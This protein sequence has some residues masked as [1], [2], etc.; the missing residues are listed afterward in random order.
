[1][2]GTDGSITFSTALDNKQLEKELAK[3]TK[4]VGKIESQ[5][6]KNGEKRLPIAKQVESLGF[7]LDTAKAKLAA[8]QEEGRRVSAALVGSNANDPASISAYTDAAARQPAL[9]KELAAAQKSVDKLQ[10]KFDKADDQLQSVD[11]TAKKLASDLETAKDKAGK[12]T[13]ELARPETAGERMGAAIDHAGSKMDAFA[14]RVKGLAR[15]V[16]VFTVITAAFRSIKNWMG[17]VVSANDEAAASLAK[18]KGA[19]LTMAQPLMDVVVPAFIVLLNVLTRIV[20]AVAGLTSLLFG[21]T[22]QQSKEAAKGLDKEAKAIQA[23]GKAADAASKSLAGFDEIN[24]LGSNTSGNAGAAAAA[25]D[26]SFDTDAMGADFE[27]LLGWIKLIGTALLYWKLPEGLHGGLKTFFGLLLAVNGAIELVKSTWDAWQDGASMDNFLRML[28]S[29]AQLAAGLG[30]AFGKVGAGIGLLVTGLTMLVTGFH[31]AMEV[32]W[33]FENLLMVISG[34]LISGLGI[35]VLTGSWIPLLIAA[36]VGLLVELAVA[37]GHGGELIDGVQQISQGFVDFITGIFTGDIGRALDGLSKMFEGLK[38]VFFALLEGARDSIMSFLDWLDEKTGG[39]LHGIIQFVKGL[40]SG[41]FDWLED[42]LGAV[43]DSIEL[44]FRGL[45]EFIAGVF[46]NDWDLAWQSVKDVFKGIWNGIIGLLGTAVNT[47][48]KGV[49]WVIRKL[50]T[51]HFDVPDWVPEIGG[52]T[53]GISI[54]TVSEWQIPYLAKGAVIPPNREFLAVLGDQKS[55]NNIEGP[56]SLFRKIV[57]EESGG[58][59]LSEQLLREILDAIREGKVLVVGKRQIGEV[60]SEALSN[61]AR[62]RGDATI[63]L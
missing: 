12:I 46:S 53:I 48:I 24:Q 41:L 16:F 2:P 5:L 10:A 21:K 18:L 32:G 44:I 11:N 52:E 29:G 39:R 30:L 49:N 13:E 62:A 43:I 61:Q 23:T 51:V 26:F 38:L 31:D 55:G 14:K 34:L 47:I 37:T 1:M 7:E 22:I 9:E 4:Y 60:V 45:T 3:A 63:P 59:V 28:G 40:F 8:L 50:N 57:R 6:Q 54:P 56:E 15:R 58:S 25:P 36:I 42:T 33:N 27:K 20:T 19:M 17:K 35:A